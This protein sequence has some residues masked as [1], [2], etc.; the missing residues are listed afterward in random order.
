[1]TYALIGLAA[2]L[3]LLFLR[4]P[5]GF[6]MAIVGFGGFSLLV[7]PQASLHMVGQIIFDNAMSYGFSVLPLFLLMGTLIARSRLSEELFEAANAFLG[8]RRGGLAMAT[9][10]ASGGF[11]AVCGSS[12]ATAVTMAKIAI[13]SMRRYGYAP[14]LSTGSVAAGGTIGILIPPSIVMVIYGFATGTDIGKLFIAG[15]IPGILA[16]VLLCLTVAVVV[17]VRPSVA[18]AGPRTGWP[19]RLRALS[20]V[21]GVV[22]LFTVVIGSLYFGICT[23]TE[24]AGLGAFAAALFALARRSLTF[25]TAFAALGEAAH[26]TALMFAILFGGLIFANFVEVAGLPHEL[27]R[28]VNGLGVGPV[29]TILA[30]GLIYLILGCFVDTVSMILLT[31]PIFFPIVMAQGIDPVWFGVAVVVAAEIGL[32]TPPLGLNIFVMRTVVPDIPAA[33]MFRGVIPFVAAEILL[34]LLIVAFPGIVLFLPS[35]MG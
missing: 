26:T 21:W 24:A 18:E 30:I 15:I 33:T 6:A 31:V 1:M 17:A 5:I 22:L 8:H 12:T 16:V 25:A 14:T 20:R 9:I 10:A 35:M 11:S 7:S 32:M 23:P 29:A 19:E 34:F 27:A 28:W 4:M 13:P 3:L 2:L